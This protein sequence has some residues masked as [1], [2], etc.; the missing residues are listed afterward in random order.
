MKKSGD[1]Q[2]QSDLTTYLLHR[3]DVHGF[4]EK[5][6]DLQNAAAHFKETIKP[7]HL[8]CGIPFHLTMV[9]GNVTVE[10]LI[11]LHDCQ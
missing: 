4:L 8:I 2:L 9:I 1:R 7:L 10:L 6:F 3:I 11:W 5:V